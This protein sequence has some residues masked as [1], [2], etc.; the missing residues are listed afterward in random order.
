MFRTI[1]ANA[2]RKMVELTVDGTLLRLPEGANLAAALL[3]FE[4]FPRRSTVVSG[5][6]RAP[7]CMMGVCFDCLVE[8]DGIPN[9]QSCLET[10]RAGMV[11]RRQNGAA[12]IKEHNS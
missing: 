8:I 9:R 4:A 3:G 11:L 12:T 1:E 7:Y 5:A 6:K 10:V 2:E